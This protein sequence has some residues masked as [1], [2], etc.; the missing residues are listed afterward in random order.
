MWF[1]QPFEPR[2]ASTPKGA[3][4]A[5]LGAKVPGEVSSILFYSH[6]DVIKYATPLMRNL[7]KIP[8]P[9][10]HRRGGHYP[11]PHTRARRRRARG[12]GAS[13]RLRR[14][15]HSEA[16]NKATPPHH[17]LCPPSYPPGPHRAFGH[18]PYGSPCKYSSI[19]LICQLLFFWYANKKAKKAN[20]SFLALQTKEQIEAAQARLATRYIE[21]RN[22]KRKTIEINI[23]IE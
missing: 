5:R 15:P 20:F 22:A 12:R 9:N 4:F 19:F 21:I 11:S 16:A 2:A 13:P 14:R 8:A 1:F 10:Y 7:K 18:S 23:V 6:S 3:V 17:P